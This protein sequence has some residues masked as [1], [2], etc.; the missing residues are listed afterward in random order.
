[1]AAIGFPL[2]AADFGRE[3]RPAMAQA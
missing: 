3:P 2:V 1:V